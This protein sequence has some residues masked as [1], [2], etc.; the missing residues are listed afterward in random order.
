MNVIAVKT[1]FYDQTTVD[2]IKLRTENNFQ[3]VSILLCISLVKIAIEELLKNGINYLYKKIFHK[4][5]P[6]MKK[7]CHEFFIKKRFINQRWLIFI[8]MYES[9]MS[10]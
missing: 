2:E 3:K 4:N 5:T 6:K 10:E 8:Q 9:S 7:N 1:E